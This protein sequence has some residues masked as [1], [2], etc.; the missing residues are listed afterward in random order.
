VIFYSEAVDERK[1]EKTWTKTRIQNLWRHRSG[2]Y[3]GRLNRKGN[4]QWRCLKTGLL[5][6]AKARLREF[7]GEIEKSSAP[8]EAR[9]SDKNRY[10]PDYPSWSQA[11]FRH[12]IAKARDS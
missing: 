8:D 7:T 6:V 11:S 12:P 10:E 2:I 3:Y 5:D 9:S 4:D 1:T